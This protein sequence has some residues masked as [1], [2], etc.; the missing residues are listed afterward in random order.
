[1]LLLG[2]ELLGHPVAPSVVDV[3]QELLDSVDAKL[4]S[5]IT[6]RSHFVF[7]GGGI[8]MASRSRALSS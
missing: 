2:I 8:S 5:L 7:L 4:P 3:A 6:D 1:M